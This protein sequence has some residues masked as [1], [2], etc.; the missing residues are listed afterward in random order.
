MTFKD[1][2]PLNYVSLETA[3]VEK[4]GVVLLIAE[5]FIISYYCS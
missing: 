5:T 4:G 1:T 3:Q 2:L